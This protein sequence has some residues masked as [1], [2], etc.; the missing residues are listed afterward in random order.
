[1]APKT[2][3]PTG[4]SVDK[5][6]EKLT[7]D[8]TI[9]NTRGKQIAMLLSE[10]QVRLASMR[11]VNSAS[12]TLSA[13]VQ[14]GWK[15]SS[16]KQSSTGASVIASS[17]AAA[18]HLAVLRQAGQK[19]I[20][21]ERA[22]M[23][24]LGKLVA[25]EMYDEA[26]SALEALYLGICSLH[27]VV[28]QTSRLSSYLHLL[29]IP[30]PVS[31]NANLILLSLTSSY[32]TYAITLL[33][34]VC[35]TRQPK[36]PVLTIE[37]FSQALANEATLIAWVPRCT[38]IPAKQLD[39]I[40]TRAYTTLTKVCTGSKLP[41]QPIFA[42]RM[43]AILCLA[44]TSPGTVDPTTFW[45]QVVRF[46][47]A[48]FKSH[49]GSQ[50]D[51][52]KCVLT[53]FGDLVGQ[54]KKRDTA[55]G[56]FDA[57]GFLGFCEYWMAFA[58]K[59]GDIC[60][61][62]HIAGV[63]QGLSMVASSSKQDSPPE[64]NL[65]KEACPRKKT[66]HDTLHAARLC[67]T[68]A[69]ATTALE[70]N[71]PETSKRIEESIF[72]LKDV[73]SILGYLHHS[74]DADPEYVRISG[75][76][77]RALERLRRA[78]MTALDSPT[79]SSPE[80][81]LL[82]LLRQIAN[83][84]PQQPNHAQ[85]DADTIT[86]TLETLFMLARMQLKP[87]DP[88]TYIPAHDILSTAV[89]LVE[90]RCADPNIN[91]PNYLRCISGAFHNLAATLYHAGRHG[92]AVGFLKDA[93][94]LG[95]T[96]L[97]AR[98]VARGTSDDTDMDTRLEEGWK[99]LEEQL[100]R[101]WELLGVCYS[102]IGDRKQALQAFRHC[103]KTF[104]YMISGF[105]GY[106]SQGSYDSLFE[107]SSATKQLATIIDRFTILGACLSRYCTQYRASAQLWRAL[108]AHRR[109]DANQST[110]MAQYLENAC[111]L[112]RTALPGGAPETRSAKKASP[113]QIIVSKKQALGP[114]TR[115]RSTRKAAVSREPV[116]PKPKSRKV[117]QP[118]SLNIET[119]PRQRESAESLAM[120][121]NFEKLLSLLQLVA[122]IAGILA[123]ILPKVHLLDVTRRLCDCQLGI[124]SDGYIVSS[125]DLAYECI[126]MGKVRR[127][128]TIFNQ[129][130]DVVRSGKASEEAS[131]AY[132][133][134]LNL[135]ETFDIE[136]KGPST[137][138]RVRMR[139]GR[140]ERAALASH[141]FGLI[142]YFKDDVTKAL[143]S[144]LQSLRLWNRAIDV[145]TRLNPQTSTTPVE[146]NPFQTTSLR[147]VLT[148]DTVS[149][150]LP[151]PKRNYCRRPSMDALEWRVSEGLLA[152]MFLL[153]R[154][155][156]NRGSSREAE[157][158]T[159]QAQDLAESLNTP[160]QVSRA[161]AKRGEVL[162]Y[163][164]L[165]DA[166]SQCL[167]KAAR[168]VGN[169]PGF[170]SVD[171]HRLQ[172]LYSERVAHSVEANELYEESMNMMEELDQIFKHFDGVVFGRKSVGSS[173]ESKPAIEVVLPELFAAVLRQRIWLLRDNETQEY[174]TFLNKFLS[175]PRSS[176]TQAQENALMA[177]LTLHAVY[178]QFRGDMFL[179]SLAESPIAL[180]MGM[181]SKTEVSLVSVTQ[182]IATTLD[183]AEKLFW[184]NLAL[185]NRRGNVMDVRDAATSLA[186][187][188]AF[189][190][191]LGK[192]GVDGPTLVTRLLDA[193]AT[194]TLRREM[195][196]AIER[197]FPSEA[198]DDVI[199]PTL[200]PDGL[201][202]QRLKSKKN[203]SSFEDSLDS[204]V[205]GVSD[206]DDACLKKYWASIRTRYHTQLLDPST[207]SSTQM[208][209]LPSNWTVTHISVT[210]DKS[211][212]FITRQECGEPSRTPLIFCVPLKGRRDTGSGQDEEDHLSF[213]DA[214]GEFKEIVRLSDE[215]TRTAVTIKA[216]DQEA[217]AAWWKD[218][219]ALDTRLRELLENI[220][221]C[222]L[223]A[224]KKTKPRTHKKTVSQSQTQI[225]GRVTFD[226]AFLECFSTLSPKCRDE[227][228]EDLVYFVLD[229]YQFHGVPVA[230]A[231]VDIIQAVIDLRAV[232]EDHAQKLSRRKI[233]KNN[234][235][236]L[237]LV[238]DKN[239]QGL[240][241]ESIPILRGR[242]ISRIPS[243]DFLHDRMLFAKY[244]QQGVSSGKAMPL[245]GAIVDPRKGYY[246]LNPSGDLGRTQDRFKGWV[247]EMEKAGWD[248]IT[249]HPPSEQQF[250]NA[251]GSKDLVVY[252]G[253]GGG[254]QYLRSHK[255]RH[256]PICAAT[257]LWGCSSG[258][259]RDMG[260]FDRVGTPYNYMLAG[261]PCL[262]ANLWDVT[263]RDID[264][265]SQNV[266]D[267]LGLT[268][269]GSKDWGKREGIS[270]VDAVGQS[271][272][273]CK[274]KY[275]TGAAPIVYGI[276]FY[277]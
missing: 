22:A 169:T 118:L 250:L 56:F 27:D 36:G 212:L 112:L 254:E 69:Q 132:C 150:E 54:L 13:A 146:D 211:T 134:A 241:W 102:K 195:L 107:L 248:G 21:V 8:L 201:P 37:A 203:R 26:M 226:D 114:P 179:S 99:Q 153:G 115:Q 256:L 221:F 20:D 149:K 215:G 130:L 257:M 41:P 109:M 119:P 193:S 32:L 162:L 225:L 242:S 269:S 147:E 259:L 187:L 89:G 78:T 123:L 182:D 79:R 176:Q 202:K 10:E 77:D 142:Q 144:M 156:L 48:F 252:F 131:I 101:R 72:I 200:G 165:F 138:Q 82:P 183:T 6:A 18:K 42:L 188:Q 1:M 190:T 5:L 81:H 139:V 151:L 16:S 86:R 93:C 53:A 227:E 2:T 70:Q 232:L 264:K 228:L 199:W 120:F 11:S 260:D 145:L 43:Y 154:I 44:H 57:R 50:E 209:G 255:I 143:D 174:T 128:T 103:I 68:F 31:E 60:L 172:G 272:E 40:L 180:P 94:A 45:D 62:D 98:R 267:K 246:I 75:K 163:Q 166:S 276:P 125:I 136:E 91:A 97:D 204:D 71:S 265:F 46:G 231:E 181:S 80:D 178:G 185:I 17:A 177:R 28:P 160:T 198:G 263:D 251:L 33:T 238:L 85:P 83:I 253:H 277:L 245:K 104:P 237:F 55:S 35:F 236:H 113:M 84:L 129:V 175:L 268:A 235:E 191:S 218:R 47:G 92:S 87:S 205:G 108:H 19:D 24:V 152:T 126:K 30:F 274:L 219:G 4:I 127:A 7:S 100:Y 116:T 76:V 12:Q 210:E 171:V 122:R 158:F 168:L 233:V 206:T 222:W 137:T 173:S 196:E 105:T 271:R 52:M 239:L 157:Y 88:R 29:S 9:S 167:A 216:Q 184:E 15:K 220:E 63:I 214:L 67:A 229:L 39:P 34:H 38:S 170:E 213:E 258:A 197:K 240:P 224:F 234:D 110:L 155:Y 270:V 65:G 59:A 64:A 58:K 273:S 223:G 249:G 133:E 192:S 262:V 3:R 159:Q 74:K 121:D 111:V 208:T 61:V 96:A 186:L 189:Q 194:I 14:S 23:S 124:H 135:S 51:A 49:S 244:R 164:G 261:S 73:E 247:D 243:V 140:L 275:L 117:L 148:P 266:F 141:V 217:R 90:P 207:L 230:I 161:L 95:L 66:D 106:A 25:L